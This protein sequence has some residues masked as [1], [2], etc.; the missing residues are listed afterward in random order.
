MPD[1]NFLS[2]LLPP[3]SPGVTLGKL[4]SS[5]QRFITKHVTLGPLLS[6]LQ[7]QQRQAL[8]SLPLIYLAECSQTP[9]GLCWS[10]P[11]LLMLRQPLFR[12]RGSR[13]L[14]QGDQRTSLGKRILEDAQTAM[15]A[16]SSEAGGSVLNCKQFAQGPS[17]SSRSLLNSVAAETT[18]RFKSLRNSAVLGSKAAHGC[19][20]F[21]LH[22]DALQDGWIILGADF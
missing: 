1:V 2:L 13:A 18:L 16:H 10:A 19:L 22:L 9:L 11:R 12:G 17:L 14:P 21:L 5:P 4:P 3:L 15:S 20:K 7:Q 6:T 8:C